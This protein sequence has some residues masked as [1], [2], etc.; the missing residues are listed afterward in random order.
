MMWRKSANPAGRKRKII[1]T[2]K[3]KRLRE[4]A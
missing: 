1:S 3:G 2:S 4:A